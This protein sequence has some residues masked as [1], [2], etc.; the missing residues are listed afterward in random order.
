MALSGHLDG[1]DT[2]NYTEEETAMN[3][4]V[5]VPTTI[6]VGV[7]GTPASLAALRWSIALAERTRGSIQAVMAWRYPFLA[8]MPGLIGAVP[9][10]ADMETAA[11]QG[12]DRILDSVHTGVPIEPVAAMGS[13]SQVLI[14]ASR[15][16]DLLVVG[17]RGTGS[18][19]GL[20]STSRHC[21]I[22]SSTS[23]AVIPEG[24]EPLA[25]SPSVMVAVDG[26]PHSIDALVWAARAFGTDAKIGVCHSHDE[27][28]LDY[29]DL[30]DEVRSGLRQRAELRLGDAV[31]RA[32][33][34]LETPVE[35]EQHVYEGDPRSTILDGAWGVDVLVVGDRGNSGVR[36]L[37][38]GSFASYAVGQAEVPVVI[39]RV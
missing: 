20:G 13:G 12:L 19:R 38:L 14:D 31:D 16:Q 26:S 37:L 23:V 29:H 11:L 24:A 34:R 28:M 3:D 36:G 8:T 7:D 2:R 32:L 4:R 27:Q 18:L 22:H 9:P 17:R 5:R 30:P 15:G 21:A 25:A 39:A 6:T 33:V 1:R 35:L 10:V